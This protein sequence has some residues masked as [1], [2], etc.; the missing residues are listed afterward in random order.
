MDIAFFW[1]WEFSANILS[2]LIEDFNDEI[3]V[4]LVVSQPDKAV[5]R[6]R[7]LI[8]TPVKK[9]AN[10]NNLKISQPKKLRKNLEFFDEL[11]G[12]DL[13]FIVVVAYW[14]IVP[15]EILGAPKK[16]CINIHWSILPKYRWASP[17]QESIKNWDTETWLTI[18]YMSPWMDE[19]DILKIEK[20]E[21]WK[22]DK[23]N[24]IFKKF[25]NIGSKLLVNTLN[26]ISNWKILWKKQ[27][28]SNATYC[29]K[30]SKEDWEV[31]FKEQSAQ[32]IYNKYRAY[33]TWPWIYSYYKWKKINIED[34]NIDEDWFFE[35]EYVWE[36]KPWIVIKINK[37]NYAIVWSDLKFLIL[38][39]VKLEW[40]NS[41]DIISFINWNK[42]FIGYK[43]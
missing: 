2:S 33:S 5:W 12:L 16:W 10:K 15:E 43:F 9:I 38:N 42:D 6:K 19:W 30:I 25:E 21:I 34:C 35:K 27:I 1:T 24:D 41:M 29:S 14:K 28:D 40:K 23:T 39:Q 13:D 22:N 8:P 32:V 18:M 20:I 4:K 3:N 7:E 17:I 26:W 37:K 36:I 11:K 31:K